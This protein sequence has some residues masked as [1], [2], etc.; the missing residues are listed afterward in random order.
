MFNEQDEQDDEQDL[1]QSSRVLRNAETTIS[2]I[3]KIQLS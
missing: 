2:T 1:Q 3:F